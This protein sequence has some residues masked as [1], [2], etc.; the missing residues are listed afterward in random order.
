MN[1][2]YGYC[3]IPD[4]VKNGKHRTTADPVIVR[5]RDDYFL[6]STN[7]WGYWWSSDLLDWNFVPRKFLKP[8]HKVYDEL[9]AP[10]AFVMNDQL[11]VIGS[12]Y[13]TD[14]TLWKSSNPRKDDWTP[15]IDRFPIGAWDPAFLVDQGKLFLYHGSS[16]VFPL[17]A[18][19]IDPVDFLPVG[20]FRE[21]F[22]LDSVQHGWE[23]F[24]ES[25][26]NV[27]LKPFLE[28]AWM[29]RRADKYYMQYSAPGT[30][31][32]G[33]ADGVYVGNSPMGPFE[34]QKHNPFSSKLGGF[35]R[36]AG[37]GATF[38]SASGHW[39]HV[40]TTTICVKNNF[41]RRIGLWPVYFDSE[42]T[43]YCDTAY[44]DYPLQMPPNTSSAD[45]PSI[46]SLASYNS[47]G[48]FSGWMLLNY[49][50]PVRVSSSLGS[51]FAANFAVDEDIKTYWSATTGGAG[52]F[53]ESDLGAI[54]HVH[55]V[56]IN[57]ADQDAELMG[58]MPDL[59]HAYRVMESS[60]GKQWNVMIDRSQQRK[61]APHDYVALPKPVKTRYLRLEN[62]HI[63]TGKFAISGFR[64]FGRG[65]GSRPKPVEDFLSL[66]GDTDRR[67][68]WLK[69][70][71]QTD[72]TG[73]VI[74]WGLSPEK[75]YSSV[76]VYAQ[77]EY[78]LRMLDRDLTYYFQIEAFNENGIG[79]RSVPILSE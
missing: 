54:S 60:D 67:A 13:T 32:S 73:Y 78:V 6:F 42:N 21:L 15:A 63:P 38:E 24:G 77:N 12:T 8:E 46:T 68:T 45:H 39:W 72:A 29:N 56:Q 75:L 36:G 74:R 61:D 44:G 69:W 27:F 28:G 7:Q 17:Y 57:Y 22:V 59:Y 16:N 65:E 55:A 30:E 48:L 23:R 53:L 41:E 79:D 11:Y 52:E 20:R 71:P 64:V 1:L 5:F 3:P 40:A 26:D 33:Y 34:Y 66:R 31:F 18:Q 9:C 10:A 51:S 25:H 4:F 43:M 2:D 19:E 62:V 14:F 70:K 35:N 76:M 50:K 49:A 47:N 58:K 37:H